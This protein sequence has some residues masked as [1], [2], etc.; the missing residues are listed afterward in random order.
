MWVWYPRTF[1]FETSTMKHLTTLKT[2]LNHWRRAQ[3]S[4]LTFEM[5]VWYLKT[6]RKFEMLT[7]KHF[8]RLIKIS[9]YEKYKKCESDTLEHSESLKSWQWSIGLDRQQSRRIKEED[10]SSS[11]HLKCEPLKKTITVQVGIWNVSV[12]SE[13]IQKVRNIYDEVF[14]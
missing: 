1:K 2:I 9:K 7:M 12:I 4:R 14:V 5:W 10:N 8:P 13:I 6:I 3:Q 11:R